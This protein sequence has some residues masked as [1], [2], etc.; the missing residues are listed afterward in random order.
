MNA[1]RIATLVGLAVLLYVIAQL[2][3]ASCCGKWKDAPMRKKGLHLREWHHGYGGAALGLLPWWPIQ[4]VGLLILVDDIAQHL[5]QRSPLHRFAKSPLHRAAH[6]M[7][8]I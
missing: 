3:A 5:K 2:P 1:L 6:H 8:L 7:G 4:V